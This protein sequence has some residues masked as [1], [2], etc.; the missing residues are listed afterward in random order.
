MPRIQLTHAGL[1]LANGQPLF[2]GVDLTIEQQFIAITGPNG[3]GKSHLLK[4]LSGTQPLTTGER[5]AQG[6]LFYLP[7]DAGSR[8]KTIA[9]MLGL[10]EKL[11]ALY[12]VQQGVASEADF[13]LI[14]DDWLL[15]SRW[16]A[17]LSPLSLTLATPFTAQSPGE[18]MRAYLQVL[19]S[20]PAIL[21]V[22]E[23]SNHMDHHNRLWLAKQLKAHHP[24]AVVVTHD[25][26]LLEAADHIVHLKR[27]ELSH[28]SLGFDAFREVLA[29]QQA[30]QKQ[31]HLINR[32][33]QKALKQA[34]VSASMQHQRQESKG[35]AQVRS[36]SQSKLVADFKSDRGARRLANQAKKLL[37]AQENTK[38][39]A[40]YYKEEKCQFHFTPS[41]LNKEKIT[42]CDAI[43]AFA[44]PQPLNLSTDTTQRIRVI[45]KNGAGKSTLL[46]TIAG[47]LSLQQG[48]IQRPSTCIYLDQHCSWFNP[49]DTL[50]E[51]AER[52][53][54][55]PKNEI[56][57][58]FASIGIRA[59]QVTLPI[60]QLSGGE[61]MKAAI[62][63][64]IQLQG[65]LLLDEPDNHLDLETQQELATLLN[66]LPSGFM[67][68]S[69]NAFFCAQL[70]NIKALRL[71]E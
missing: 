28:H 5:H 70:N 57:T 29:Q 21:L 68:V 43:L 9:E 16:Q 59:S 12:R 33:E 56:M 22:D 49:N 63:I 71:L 10:S 30:Q 61:K 18:R 65:F 50:I 32:A 13:V 62:V 7:Q 36:G 11:A 23:P 48:N 58:S 15:E 2:S 67:L 4:V 64:A 6:P 19:L 34:L 1:T 35:K 42:L 44:Q 45:G 69:H 41:N 26:V 17:Q 25:P 39:N 24:G 51:I 37:Q 20:Q 53:L 55:K 47:K 14:D 8:F 40:V 54:H 27:T 60:A 3:A 31:Q 46:K 52:L 38:Q 66:Q